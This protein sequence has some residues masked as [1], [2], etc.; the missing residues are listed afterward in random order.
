M[1]SYNPPIY[2]FNGIGFD[3]AYFSNTTLSL[4]GLTQSQ[5]NALY[6][7]KTQADNDPFQATFSA[8]L[9]TTN[10]QLNT[11]TSTSATPTLLDETTYTTV[12][13]ANGGNANVRIGGSMTNT[14]IYLAGS[15]SFAG[16]VNIA[17]SPLAV[18][19]T[20]INTGGLGSVNI[21]QFVIN[22]NN[23]TNSVAASAVNLFSTTTGALSIGSGASMPA[24]LY[25]I[26][27]FPN[28][29]TTN[30]Y[31]Y[32]AGGAQ[33]IANTTDTKI[34]YSTAVNTGTSG[35]TYSAGNFTNSSTN[36]LTIVGTYSVS[37]TS[38]PTGYRTIYLLTGTTRYGEVQV[39]A[40]ASVIYVGTGSFTIRLAPAASFSVYAYQNSGAILTALQATINPTCIDFITF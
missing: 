23:I 3:S 9:V 12:R 18:G 29:N 10:A 40:P 30:Y 27:S 2:W 22:L 15:N 16:N 37:M 34:T 17:S 31:S 21:S 32:V 36:T 28:Y 19:N 7:Q 1:S 4:G 25:G 13:F 38:N 20:N 35:I 11:M 33:T 24:Y 14:S 8:G 39:G 5:A 6:L 26:I